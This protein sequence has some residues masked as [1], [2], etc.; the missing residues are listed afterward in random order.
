MYRHTNIL[1]NRIENRMQYT[2]VNANWICFY[3]LY[4]HEKCLYTQRLKYVERLSV[5]HHDKMEYNYFQLSPVLYVRIFNGTTNVHFSISTYTSQFEF[6]CIFESKAICMGTMKVSKTF[7]RLLNDCMEIRNSWFHLDQFPITFL[8]SICL[9]LYEETSVSI[10]LCHSI[11]FNIFIDFGF[12][13]FDRMY[14]ST[15][16]PFKFMQRMDIQFEDEMNFCRCCL[17]CLFK[18]NAHTLFKWTKYM[19]I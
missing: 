5:R 10:F 14:I 19:N 12:L 11:H 18:H 17:Y 13:L 2:S 3:Q 16:C 6:S 15:N 1:A 7:E 4:L 9:S 8:C